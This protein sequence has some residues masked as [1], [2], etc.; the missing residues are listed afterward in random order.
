[1][2]EQLARFYGAK[3]VTQI[4]SSV[5]H[6]IMESKDLSRWND[7]RSISKKLFTQTQKAIH[8]ISQD[9]VEESISTH[10][11]LDELSFHVSQLLRKKKKPSQPS[12]T[13]Q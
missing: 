7:I 11:D 12:Q 1:M 5:T 8:I 9:W 6:V 3:V 10:E 13:S 4:S 2:T